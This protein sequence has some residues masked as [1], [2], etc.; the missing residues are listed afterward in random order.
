[1]VGFASLAVIVASFVVASAAANANNILGL[2][3][4]TLEF[5]PAAFTA[6]GPSAPMPRELLSI[7]R[8]GVCGGSMRGMLLTSRSSHDGGVLYVFAEPGNEAAR[9]TLFLRNDRLTGTIESGAGMRVVVSSEAPALSALRVEDEAH[10]LPCLTTGRDMLGQP[11]IPAGDGGVAGACDDGT[12]VDVLVV[13][14]DAAVAQIGDEAALRDSISWLIAYSNEIYAGSG[15][16]LTA[17]LVGALPVH[18]YHE[19]NDTMA[20]DLM[21]LTE[22]T[23]G[24]LDEVHALRDTVGADL[25]ALIRSGNSDACGI[26]WILEDNT[27]G[28]AA[29]GFSVVSADCIGNTTF[30]HELGHNMGCCHAPEDGGGC[31]AGGV[32][33]YATG[34]RFY[35]QGGTLCRTVMAYTP[36]TSSPRFSSPSVLWMGA[37]TGSA[38]RDNARAISETKL[39]FTNFRCAID[40]PLSCGGSGSCLESRET[41]GCGDGACCAAVCAIDAHCCTS[42]WDAPCVEA[43]LALCSGCGEPAAG[44]C[45]MH[46]THRGCSDAVCCVEVCAIDAFC[47]DASWD[48]LCASLARTA[49]LSCGSEGTDSCFVTHGTAYCNEPTC[50]ATVCAVDPSCCE[51][52]WDADCVASASTLCA[53]CGNPQSGLCLEAHTMPACNDAACCSAVCVSDPACCSAAWDLSCA[54]AATQLCVET[55]G[56]ALAG[57]CCAEHTNPGCNDSVCCALVCA[58]DARCCEVAWDAKCVAAAQEACTACCPSDLNQDRSVSAIDL[59]LLL[60]AWGSEWGDLNGDGFVN[61][62]DAAQMLSEWGPCP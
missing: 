7:E 36:G 26:A 14:T 31:A 48:G 18:G 12:V 28:A 57:S 35:E 42:A 9:A 34:H 24:R 61:A 20:I 46:H 62:M 32:F 43:A 41:P 55:C 27:A 3:G 30:T 29:N 50:C 38:T 49:C 58:S 54:A 59:A 4:E 8:L 17:R 19:S 45:L 15:I 16:A 22:R 11:A 47:C 60:Q 52:G 21:L 5:D 33:P 25:V 51:T 37:A 53:V 56:G 40:G 6:L 23:D 1:M 13:Y 10:D 2:S 39:A 44:S